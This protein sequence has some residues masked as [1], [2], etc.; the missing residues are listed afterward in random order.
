[1]D[2]RCRLSDA[3]NALPQLEMATY[4][5]TRLALVG[6]QIEPIESEK[7][8]GGVDWIRGSEA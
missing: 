5:F 3:V 2:A 7:L 4:H 8:I 1:M 6:L